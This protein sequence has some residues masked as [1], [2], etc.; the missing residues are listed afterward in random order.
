LIYRALRWLVVAALTAMI[1]YVLLRSD[2]AA[3]APCAGSPDPDH[4]EVMA[5]MPCA[6]CCQAASSDAG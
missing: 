3:A 6:P 5:A 1:V 4:S 2:D